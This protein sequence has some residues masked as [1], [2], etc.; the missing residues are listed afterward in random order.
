[1]KKI[2]IIYYYCEQPLELKINAFRAIKKSGTTLLKTNQYLKQLILLSIIY[3]NDSRLISNIQKAMKIIKLERNKLEN[4]L[5][6]ILSS[7]YLKSIFKIETQLTDKEMNILI[8]D[9]EESIFLLNFET[10]EELENFV[11]AYIKKY[12]KVNKI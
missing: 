12:V 1:M 8:K 11:I 9:I 5:K 10:E 7:E 3:K 2:N 6:L 4:A